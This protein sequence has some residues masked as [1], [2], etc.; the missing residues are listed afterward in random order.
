MKGQRKNDIFGRKRG[1]LKKKVPYMGAW[2]TSPWD[3]DDAADWFADF[4]D[5]VDVD[6]RITAAFE[7]EDEHDQIRAACYML[8]VLGRT[9]V[10]PGDLDALDSLL[11]RGKELLSTMLEEGSEFREL[12]EDDE[13]VL[14]AVEEELAGLQERLSE[15]SNGDEES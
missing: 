5:S 8:N 3:N 10:W 1:R 7:D 6:A 14:A 12:W 2:G 9:Y 15:K 11:E 4:F 13:E